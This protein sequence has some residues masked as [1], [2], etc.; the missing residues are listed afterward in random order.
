MRPYYRPGNRLV[1]Y[2]LMLV[3]SDDGDSDGDDGD[4]TATSDCEDNV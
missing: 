1:V 4:H 3:L 2:S